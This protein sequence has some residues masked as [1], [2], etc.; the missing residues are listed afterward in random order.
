MCIQRKKRI[1]NV[2]R[3]NQSGKVIA[4]KKMIDGKRYDT[5]AARKIGYGMTNEGSIKCLYVK[6][7]A[8]AFLTDGKTAEPITHKNAMQWA[9]ENHLSTEYNAAIKYAESEKKQISIYLTVE[10]ERN[11]ELLSAQWE[12]SRSEVIDSMI[13]TAMDKLRIEENSKLQVLQELQLKIKSK[14]KGQ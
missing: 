13:S 12:M 6:R 4:M 10:N 3:K 11:L 9:I 2:Q 8:E 14:D 5:S 1:N 7:N